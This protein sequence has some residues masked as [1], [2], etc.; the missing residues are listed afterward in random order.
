MQQRSH[1]LARL[2][3]GLNHE[4]GMNVGWNVLRDKNRR[5][6]SAV[7]KGDFSLAEALLQKGCDVEQV[8]T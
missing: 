3:P 8:L 5:L 6:R 1:S 4:P 2:T 7:Y